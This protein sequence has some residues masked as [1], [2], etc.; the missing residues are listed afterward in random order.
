MQSSPEGN[1][2]SS[3]EEKAIIEEEGQVAG[4]ST[5]NLKPGVASVLCYVGFW[6]TGIIFLLI[7]R[8]NR[9][10]RFH[11]MQSLVTFGVLNII[12][13]TANTVR[14]WFLGWT[15]PGWLWH[16]L[17]YPQY[18]AATTVFG[19][20]L[21]IWWVL[22]IV[23]MYQTHQGRIVR[24]LWFGDL[25]VTLLAGLDGISK[26]DLE[27]TLKHPESQKEPGQ[28]STPAAKE[29]IQAW[30]RRHRDL[31]GTRSGRVA[32][33]S[34]VVAWS[35]V[36]LVFFN[37][38]SEYFAYYQREIMDGVTEWNIYPL[39]TQEFSLVLPILN[40]T[41]ILTIAGHIALIAIDR[42]LLRQITVLVLNILGMVTVVTFLKVFPFDFGAIPNTSLVTI[43]P[44]IAV[45]VL[46]VMAVGL[47]I[48]VVVR[49]VKLIVN[50]CERG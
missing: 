34:A 38:F 48:G 13:G 27:E 32:S 36:L 24:V 10:V 40:T 12:W 23:L 28:P 26:Q 20:F 41:L 16:G 29:K 8:K 19:V 14:Y 17:V 42:Y 5:T 33:S 35:A 25:A 39:L 18:V 21:A 6:V 47:G 50:L 15:S 4:D 30:D 31:E 2:K 7:E 22:W 46:I 1:G 11:A 49:F 45:A 43:L 3:E 37:L 44:T 9:L